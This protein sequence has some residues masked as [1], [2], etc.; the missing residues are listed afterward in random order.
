MDALREFALHRTFIALRRVK[1]IDDCS[2]GDHHKEAAKRLAISPQRLRQL[3]IANEIHAERH[4]RMWAIDPA[5]VEEYGRH[6]RPTAG[7]GLSTRM[8]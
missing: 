5:A 2:G 3:I 8:V 7:R 6:R 4:G 1:G